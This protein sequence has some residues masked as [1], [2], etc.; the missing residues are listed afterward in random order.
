[1][2]RPNR[3][4]ILCALAVM[5]AVP[6]CTENNLDESDADVILQ[7]LGVVNPPI[8]SEPGEC[9]NDTSKICQNDGDC[10]L[11]NTG[12]P[13]GPCILPLEACTISEWSVSM[14]NSPLNEGGS[15]GPFNDIVV[16]SL[17]LMYDWDDAL[18]VPGDPTSASIPVGQT[19]LAGSGGTVN[20]F[21]I[22]VQDI[23]ADQTTVSVTM[24]FRGQTVS[25]HA[26][27][28]AT[29]ALLSIQNCQIP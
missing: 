16:I 13:T 5:L 19:I 15:E 17:D 29:G 23:A 6:A 26:V 28:S 20:F 22:A 11:D 10:P 27:A 12:T 18:G 8:E 24:V 9:Q 2:R 3:W 21:P 1:M 7:I 14:L 4:W 25:G